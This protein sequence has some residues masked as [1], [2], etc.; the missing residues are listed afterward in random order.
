MQFNANY[1]YKT[2]PTTMRCYNNNYKW[3][4]KHQ[5]NLQLLFVSFKFEHKF[6][7]K[8]NVKFNIATK[9]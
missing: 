1:N 5:H 7:C 3:E 6:K 8:K 9:R 2:G 4:K